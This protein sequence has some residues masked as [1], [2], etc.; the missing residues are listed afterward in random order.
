MIPEMSFFRILKNIS[1]NYNAYGEDDFTLKITAS[2]TDKTVKLETQNR[3]NTN[4]QNTGEST[5]IGMTI[6]KQLLQD[7]FGENS[8]L[9]ITKNKCTYSLVISFPLLRPSEEVNHDT[10]FY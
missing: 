1:E 9:K 2:V 10:K 5:K 8:H 7:N 6:V 4:V 3:I